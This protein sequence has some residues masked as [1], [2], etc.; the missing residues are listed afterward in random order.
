MSA[1]EFCRRASSTFTIRILNSSDL[2]PTLSSIAT[3]ARYN[4]GYLSEIDP[5]HVRFDREPLVSFT[6]N[7]RFPASWEIRIH[8][9][10]ARAIL[11]AVAVSFTESTMLRLQRFLAGIKRWPARRVQTSTR[12]AG[13]GCTISTNAADLLTER[14]ARRS[15][16]EHRVAARLH[17]VLAEVRRVFEFQLVSDALGAADVNHEEY[18]DEHR[19]RYCRYVAAC[20]GTHAW[21]S[22]TGAWTRRWRWRTIRSTSSRE[23]DACGYE[24]Y[25]QTFIHWR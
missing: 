3:L 12:T 22:K 25:Y 7:M 9:V 6:G 16:D 2:F 4:E 21:R 10:F 15:H 1:N 19:S 23:V 18:G 13:V 14:G 5:C 8:S 24:D 17:R 11:P 20:A